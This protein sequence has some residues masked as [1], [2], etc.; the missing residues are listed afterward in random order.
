MLQGSCLCRQV[1]FEVS[2]VV[3]PFEL[4]HCSRCRKVSGSAFI[5]GIYAKRAG[6]RF[7]KGTDL[8]KTFDAPILE[9]PPAYRSCFC[10]TCGAPMPDPNGG[11]ALVEI[12]AG[13]L[14]VNPG[15]KPDKHIF[16]DLK[17]P[18]YEIEDGLPQF[19]KVAIRE[20]RAAHTHER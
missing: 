18:W 3:G 7:L 8:I 10:G 6:L 16:V 2:E 11:S 20:H 19:D 5:A 1:Q 4:C 13:S 17:A 9:K 14:D 15:I 12:P